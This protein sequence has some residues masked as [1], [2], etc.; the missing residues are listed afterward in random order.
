MQHVSKLRPPLIDVITIQSQVIYGSVGNGIAYRALLK[1]GLEA[2]QVPSVLF[3]CPPYYGAPSGGAIPIDWFSGFLDDLLA[4]GVA[5]RAR[6]VIVGYLGSAMQCQALEN[7]LLRVRELN[8]AIMLIIDPVMGDYGEG[9]YV[10]KPLVDCY[11]SPFLHLAN[12]ITPNGF[13]L[14][15]LCGQPLHSREHAVAAA[16]GLLNQHTRWVLVTSAPGIAQHDRQVGLLLVTP[17]ETRSFTHPKINASV[18]GTGDLFTALLTSHLLAGENISSAV[19]SASAEVCKVLTDAALN[20]WE[21]IGS[22]R[23]LQ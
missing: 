9:V 5:Q 8:P 22:L 16:Q 11:R 4:R 7:W 14:E 20:G 6:A 3:G 15:Q 13:E 1:K 12:G 2:L 10:D 21:E 18:K 19:L 23:A 17:Q